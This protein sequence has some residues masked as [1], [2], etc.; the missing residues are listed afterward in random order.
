MSFMSFG[1]HFAMSLE[2]IL[3]SFICLGMSLMSLGM[4]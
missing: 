1:M 3:M 2:I 4:V